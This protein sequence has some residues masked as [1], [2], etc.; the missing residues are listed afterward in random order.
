MTGL[1]RRTRLER[2]LKLVSSDEPARNPDVD[3][4]GVSITFGGQMAVDLFR[5]FL[6]AKVD[7]VSAPDVASAV[8]STINALEETAS[9]PLDLVF[10]YGGSPDHYPTLMVGLAEPPNE[11]DPPPPRCG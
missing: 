2:H 10:G 1:P 8:A 3:N 4:N 7:G 6:G 11:P 9:G 5:H